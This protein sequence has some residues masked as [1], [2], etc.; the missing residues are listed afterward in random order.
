MPSVELAAGTIEY[1]DTGTDGPVLVFVGGLAIGPSLWDDVVAELRGRYR[2]VTVTMPWGAHRLPMHPDADLSL[3]GH[4]AMLGEV[5]ASLGV[6]D[7]VTL[8]ENDTGMAQLVAT[9]RP[10]L[11]SRLILTSCE[12]FDNYPPGLPGKLIG[13][14][15]RRPAGVRFAMA[16]LKLRPLRRLPM[17]F[18]RMS[19]HG[20]PHERMDAWLTP[21]W[22]SGEIRRDLAKYIASVDRSVFTDNAPLLGEFDRP[23]LVAWAADDKVM[24][25]E[26]GRRL[27]D[28]LPRGEF[29]AIADSYTLIPI[30]QPVAL[31]GAIAEFV[32]RT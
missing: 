10:E 27:A 17:T 32:A 18:G 1:A 3:R 13:L 16:Q 7:G 19:K 20:I 5:I 11:L 2:C 9:S 6:A 21:L 12:A 22:T 29:V 30:D 23:A 15:G 8:I 28:L 14:V 26:H 25:I 4:A 24:P 31:A